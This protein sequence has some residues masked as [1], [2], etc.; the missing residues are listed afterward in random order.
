MVTDAFNDTL[1]NGMKVFFFFFFFCHACA[2][3]RWPPT[4]PRKRN[5][6]RAQLNLPGRLDPG[7]PPRARAEIPL[8]HVETDDL[9]YAA[10][11]ASR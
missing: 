1:R 9:P 11:P 7:A 5:C 4:R 8:A 2:A 6:S 10:S 3:S